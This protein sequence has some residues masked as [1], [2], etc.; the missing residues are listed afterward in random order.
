MMRP[1]EV[2]SAICCLL[3]CLSCSI[4]EDRGACPC[5]LVLD[6]S[7]NDS[8]SVRSAELLLSASGGFFLAD[9]LD[10]SDFDKEYHVS[11][12]AGKVN[13]QAWHGGEGCI[14]PGEGLRIPYGNDCPEV[15]MSCFDMEAEGEEMK[16]N[17][18][19]KK[20]HC[21]TT[22]YVK[23]EEPFAYRL[24]VRGKVCG[25][26]RD[27]TPLEGDFMYELK[28]HEDMIG[29]V[30]LPRQCNDSLYLEI[31]EGDTVLKVFTLGRYI[32]AVG[33]DWTAE[34]LEDLSLSLDYT[35][36]FIG[37]SIGEWDREHDFNISI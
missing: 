11:V 18:C 25:Y 31:W 30:T 26:K 10:C 34:H 36:N 19:L 28:L 8:V 32:S 14:S 21:K 7:E 13:V 15:Y 16:R 27:G 9:T 4:K 1:L 3:S 5:R 20:N 37:V 12:P 29:Y 22:I 6:F 24:V 17:V 23:S 33:Y 2:V 35:H